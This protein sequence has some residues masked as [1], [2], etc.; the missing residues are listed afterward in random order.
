MWLATTRVQ[1]APGQLKNRCPAD[2]ARASKA[3]WLTGRVPGTSCPAEAQKAKS[4]KSLPLNT[5]HHETLNK[6]GRTSP[7]EE[8]E[9]QLLSNTVLSSSRR[10][11]MSKGQRI[12]GEGIN[13]SSEQP[14][15]VQSEIDVPTRQSPC[16]PTSSCWR[17]VLQRLL[18]SCADGEVANRDSETHRDSIHQS[19]FRLRPQMVQN[20]G[21]KRDAEF[22]GT[23]TR[24]GDPSDPHPGTQSSLLHML[25]PTAGQ[26]RQ[27]T[28]VGCHSLVPENV[29]ACQSQALTS[30]TS[31]R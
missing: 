16:S 27:P 9:V 28:H 29:S 12:E 20:Y 6:M 8:C 13:R 11:S 5:E 2:S 26:H 15:K 14:L 7:C 10:P 31:V 19:S 4:N 17:A 24:H 22:R 1:V 21:G 18:Y 30:R 23:Q 3:K 25:S